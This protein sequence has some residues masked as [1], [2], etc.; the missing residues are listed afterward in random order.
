MSIEMASNLQIL[1]GLIEMVRMSSGSAQQM[2]SPPPRPGRTN[3]NPEMV[4]E[5]LNFELFFFSHFKPK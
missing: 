2:P 4:L 1:K 5:L 3:S